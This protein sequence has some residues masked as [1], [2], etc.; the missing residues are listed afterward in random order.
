MYWPTFDAATLGNMILS[1]ALA[2]VV[3]LIT[4]IITNRRERQKQ[5]EAWRHEYTLAKLS[6][7]ENRLAEMD[8]LAASIP[9]SFGPYPPSI[10]G[11]PENFKEER[12]ALVQEIAAY[13]ADIKTYHGD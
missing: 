13:Q 12:E 6:S 2:I 11:L 7:A 3:A 10:P 9:K 5:R 8:R 1:S 4:T